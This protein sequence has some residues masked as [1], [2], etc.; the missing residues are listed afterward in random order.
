MQQILCGLNPEEGPGFVDVYIDDI[1][2]FSSTMEEH[3][4]HLRRVLVGLRCA[5]LKLKP[6]KCHFLRHSIEYLGHVITQQEL[7]PNP[8]Q[9]TAVQN[10]PVTENVSQVRQFLGLTSYYRRLVKNF[11]ETASPL[12]GLTRKNAPFHWTREC[13]LAFETLKEK[14]VSAPIRVYPD[15]DRPFVLETDASVY[16]LG[17]VLSQK[18]IDDQLHPVAYARRALSAP[19]KNYGITELETLAVVWA[20][21][22]FR[23]YLYN[24]EVT[25]VTD[26]SAVRAVLETP[27]PS[28]KHARWWLKVYSSGIG[29]VSIVYR[30]GRENSKADALSRN[31]V[32]AERDGEPEVQVAQVSMTVDDR[33]MDISQLLEALPMESK[34]SDFQD[35]QRKDPN[36]LGLTRYLEDGQLPEDNLR[37]RKIAA[38]APQFA[39]VGSILYFLEAKKG[40]SEE[41]GCLSPSPGDNSA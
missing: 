36:L 38:Q 41:S 32:K 37:S 22:H 40:H 31:P 11:A 21:Q 16:G 35:K 28:G 1:L 8:N 24:H 20:L 17:A 25:V 3:V 14:L 12:H 9:V 19:E 23:A 29:K 10:F 30:P 2:V 39:L 15:F 33:E 26:H 13:Q 7:K 4:D 27:S 6:L 34:L 5:N 18:H